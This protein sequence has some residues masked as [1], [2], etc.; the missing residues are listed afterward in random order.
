M[1]KLDPFLDEDN[2]LR[3]G[4]R[5]R[6]G[7]FP[8]AAKHQIILTSH[9]QSTKLLVQ[10]LHGFH[11]HVGTEHLLSLTRQQYWIVGGRVLIK[12]TTRKCVTCQ[13]KKA[14]PSQVKMADLPEYRITMS[15]PP[16]FYTG[17]DYFG[18]IMVKIRRS[19]DKRWGCIF[20]C[21]TTR[22]VHLEV[23][24]SLESDDFINVLE[25]FICR[26]GCPNTIRSDCGTN[27]KGATD[28][29]KLELE[30]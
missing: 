1:C 30:K 11:K 21:L 28:E 8:Y 22:A 13:K 12:Q 25:R 26:R 24:P 29:L 7:E 20:T 19:H 23:S 6:R 15:T 4:G 3:V 10:H 9:H 16:F 17:V 2:V 5:L 27:F 14:K 18:P